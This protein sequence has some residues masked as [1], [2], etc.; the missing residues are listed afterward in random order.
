MS[1]E[2]GGDGLIELQPDLVVTTEQCER[3]LESWLGGR[4]ACTAVR[5]LEGGMV[6]TVYRLDFDR[7]PYRAVIKVH[8]PANASFAREARALE[9]LRTETDCPVPR[10]YLHDSSARLLPHAFILL[11]HVHGECLDALDLEPV[12][13]ADIEVQLAQ[14][15]GGLHEHTGTTWGHLDG[16]EPSTS[17]ADLFV[18]RLERARADPMLPER[19][20]PDAL[21]RVDDAIAMAG[22]ALEDCGVPTLV[23]GDVWD[24]NLI[25][26]R[27]DG[28]WRLVA[29][30]D[31]DLQY[32]DVE[33]ELAYLEV[34]DTPRNAFFGAYSGRGV[35]RPGYERRRLFYWLYTA[36]I[37]V[38]LFENEVFREFTLRTADQIARLGPG[39]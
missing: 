2:R 32:A 10:V 6:N 19:L 39:R 18:A 16:D 20:T 27:L 22:A 36:L 5:P 25:V 38:A 26:N 3:V 30:L 29:L 4:V 31:P 28:R 12:E 14:V 11:E 8:R 23:H 13:R 37:H 33:F 1:L 21:G 7:P 9:Y 17:W 15:L 24:G 34:F 35:P